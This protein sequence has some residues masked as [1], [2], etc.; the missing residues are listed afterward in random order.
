MRAKGKIVVKWQALS[1]MMS[2][3]L[4][5]QRSVGNLIKFIQHIKRNWSNGFAQMCSSS[6][7][8][9]ECGSIYKSYPEIIVHCAAFVFN[10][11][12]CTHGLQ[13]PVMGPPQTYHLLLRVRVMGCTIPPFYCA[14]LQLLHSKQA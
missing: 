5:S 2:I 14:A 3:W 12:L 7:N 6:D 4:T 9:K 13:I 10:S 11:F 1:Q 8:L